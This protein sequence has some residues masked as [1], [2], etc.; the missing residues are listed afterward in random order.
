M[1]FEITV[2]DFGINEPFVYGSCLQGFI[3]RADFLFDEF[4]VVFLAGFRPPVTRCFDSLI[5]TGI[6][7]SNSR[8]TLKG[9]DS[10]AQG[11]REARHPGYTVVRLSREP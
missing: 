9:L 3:D 10:L 11:K 1:T 2:D 7:Y 4:V 6:Y 8:A 5:L